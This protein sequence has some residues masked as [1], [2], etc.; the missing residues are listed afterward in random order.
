MH[1][2]LLGL[3]A[4]TF[5]ATLA[6][7]GCTSPTDTGSSSGGPPD[8]EQAMSY[9]YEFTTPSGQETHW[10]Q[11]TRL[12]EGDGK[13]VMVTGYTWSWENMHHWALYRTTPDLPEGV[14][15][16][17]PF[18]CF[19]PGAMKYAEFA[20]LVLA[21]GDTGE[22]MFPEGTGFAFK[23]GE[24]VIVQAHTL[25]TTAKELKATLDVKLRTAD[26]AAVP[27]PLGLIQF[28]NPYIVVPAHTEAK[29]QMRCLVPQDM[30]VL[31]ATTHE[32]VRGTGVQAFLDLPDGT[33]AAKPFIE[34]TGWEHPTVAN[35]PLKLAAG[36]HIRTVCDYLGDANDVYQGQNKEISEMCMFIGY[37]YP[38]IAPDQG[39]PFFE[40]CVQDSVP[41]GV[42]DE[43]GV[44]TQTCA[45]SLACIQTCPPGDAPSPADGRIDVGECW[46][47]CLVDS[48][49]SASAPLNT[50]GFC[51]Q[52]NCAEACSGGDCAA[53]VVSKCGSEYSA[54]QGSKC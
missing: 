44:G 21:A 42:G 4:A 22:Q 13:D 52:S 32:H 29:A 23:P 37:Y 8:D 39:G 11:Y 47:K 15:L 17:Q 14:S 6:L 48:C 27:N 50:L 7:A 10:C 2:R 5:A 41:G 49:P 34:S 54:C 18:D 12:P 28:Y 3:S 51:V 31:L 9:S 33:R 53:C 24:I 30:T 19:E 43:Y 36:S 45:Q 20:S 38:V 46:Q 26:A 40:N 25:N 1:R 35:D 16:D